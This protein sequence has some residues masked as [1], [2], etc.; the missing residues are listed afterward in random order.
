MAGKTGQQEHF[1]EKDYLDPGYEGTDREHSG[2]WKGIWG[3]ATR[4]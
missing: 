4:G 1:R 3:W 2:V